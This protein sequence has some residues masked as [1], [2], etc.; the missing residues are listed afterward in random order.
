[1]I[2]ESR[3]VI[4]DKRKGEKPIPSDIHN[5]LNEAQNAVLNKIQEFG[6]S[7]Q[8]IRRPLFQEPVVIAA[9]ANGDA[10]GVLE[11]DGHFNTE[12]DIVLRE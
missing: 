8:F 2:K 10:F 7:L 1:L 11:V 12:P 5:Y 4:K 3:E 9:N 6:W